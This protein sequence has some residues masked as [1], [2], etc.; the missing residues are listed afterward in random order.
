MPKILKT[1]NLFP[2]FEHSFLPTSIKKEYEKI[3]HAT[4]KNTL[5]IS[6]KIIIS[7]AL[8]YPRSWKTKDS[9]VLWS[10]LGQIL[11]FQEMF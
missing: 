5:P 2:M 3:E 1:V 8:T 10:V 4:T 11:N 7:Q 6:T 9:G